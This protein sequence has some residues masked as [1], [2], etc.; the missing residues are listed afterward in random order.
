MNDRKRDDRWSDDDRRPL[1]HDLDDDQGR[2]RS[3]HDRRAP[4]RR[5]WSR[6]EGWREEEAPGYR[7]HAHRPGERVVWSGAPRRE[8]DSMRRKDEMRE[9][10]RWWPADDYGRAGTRWSDR[11]DPE[12]E[13]RDRR[14]ADERWRRDITDRWETDR[15]G[16]NKDW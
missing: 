5:S 10:E 7:R 14:W 4:E 12:R 9:R 13:N 2:V 15:K 11:T 6:H 1:Q 3:E 16:S 8:E